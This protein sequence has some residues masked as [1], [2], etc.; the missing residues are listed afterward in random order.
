MAHGSRRKQ[1][2]DH[3]ES[4]FE[5]LQKKVRQDLILFFLEKNEKPLKEVLYPY[6]T[7]G[8]KNFDIIPL[9]MAPGYH[10]HE[11]IKNLM[12]ETENEFKE[13][14]ISFSQKM[15]VGGHPAFKKCLV[16]IIEDDKI[17]S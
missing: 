2:V 11:D 14:K 13:E 1:W 6:V 8:I 10:V 9:L 3:V 15:F 17:L 12:K 7:K 4:L 16:D 5:S